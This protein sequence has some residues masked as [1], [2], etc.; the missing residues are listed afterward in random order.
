MTIEASDLLV[1][2]VV[3]AGVA[4][5]NPKAG[6]YLLL[7][8]IAL[9]PEIQVGEV[10]LR[11]DDLMMSVLV[12][13]WAVRRL[14]TAREGT[15]LDRLLV[16]YLWVGVA[17]TLWG[18]VIGTADLLSTDQ[19]TASGLHAIKR[20]EFILLF[21]LVT[22]VIRT[23]HDVKRIVQV[24][25][26]SLV[27]LI[28]YGLGQFSRTGYVALAPFGAQVHE[29]GLASMLS[30]SIA[31]GFLVTSSRFATSVM[32]VVTIVGSLMALPFTLGRNFMASTAGILGFVAVSRKRALLLL[33][34]IA[35]LIVPVLLPEHVLARIGSIQW[36]FSPIEGATRAEWGPVYLPSRL[37]PAI[38]YGID[39]LFSSPLLGWGLGSVAL[40]S[41]DNEYATQLVGTGIVGLAVFVKL[42]VVIVRMTRK[43]YRT[44]QMLDLRAL[45]LVMGLQ[46]C[47][48]GYALN[49]IFS[50]SISAARPGALFFTIIGL[51]AVL[52]RVLP[53][54]TPVLKSALLR[55]SIGGG[56][57][58]LGNTTCHPRESAAN[59][60]GT[61]T[62]TK[63]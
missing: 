60:S 30:V 9:A 48:L 6:L 28:L 25:L 55:P 58:D 42:V 10:L 62:R 39:V 26:A 4:I 32:A 47:L 63:G 2:A 11:P 36:V 52:H 45:P 22:D 1:L 19:L 40:G 7:P 12:L 34:P 35:W 24:L 50:P 17:A 37:A 41:I 38:G 33:V 46:Y 15:P 13:A 29:A 27:G 54:T 3:F 23:V 31:L 61:P 5:L 21:F 59:T 8:T 56:M 20:L 44:A 49:S 14:G 16:A 43:S 57:Y 51:I 53:S 18:S